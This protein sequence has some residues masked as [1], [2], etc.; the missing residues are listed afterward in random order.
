MGSFA[1]LV[2]ATPLFGLSL[3][4]PA[5][6]LSPSRFF[7][8]IPFQVQAATQVPG[9][10]EV[11]LEENADEEA[12]A[13]DAQAD[14]EAEA[15][16]NALRERARIVSIHRPFGIATWI[17]MGVTLILGGIQYH[18]LY[19]F[20]DDRDSNPCVTGD[21]IFG[22]SQC[23]GTPWLHLTSAMMTTALYGTT[24]TLSLLMPDPD[25]SDEGDSDFAST[26][27]MHK[28]L[29]WIHF[30]GM[31]AQVVLGAV[32]GNGLLGLDRANDYDTLQLLATIHMGLG[33]VTYGAL[34]WA[35]ALMVF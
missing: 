9:G 27:R 16:T 26:L 13:E 21:A 10:S 6:N 22:Q 29:R 15:Y 31:V 12:S 14:A 5:A 20:F 18:N 23:S 19:G 25:D 2:V 7:A 34:T 32:I 28:I 35:G 4:P 33:I 30:G 24:F 17:S 3:T 8:P 1:T 11:A